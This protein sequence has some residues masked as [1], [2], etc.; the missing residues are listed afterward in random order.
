MVEQADRFLAKDFL[1]NLAASSQDVNDHR[2]SELKKEIKTCA[3]NTG[4][5]SE[6]AD[7][8]HIPYFGLC[9]RNA[10]AMN[11]VLNQSATITREVNGWNLV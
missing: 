8:E 9:L 3:N 7:A 6:D 11:P 4:F 2:V 5:T 10:V 1:R